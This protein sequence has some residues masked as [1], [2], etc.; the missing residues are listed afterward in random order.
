MGF[1]RLFGP[2]TLVRTWGTRTGSGTVHS[3]SSRMASRK[4][5]RHPYLAVSGGGSQG[6][7]LNAY[8]S[9]LLWIS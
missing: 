4:H 3:F 8:L 6:T 9:K 2:R 1:A 7:F 5:V